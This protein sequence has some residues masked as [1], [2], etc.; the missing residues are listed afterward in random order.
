M[1]PPLRWHSLWMATSCKE[2]YWIRVSKKVCVRNCTNAYP[3][4][5]KTIFRCFIHWNFFF[6]TPRV[7]SDGFK[8][9]WLQLYAAS[10]LFPPAKIFHFSLKRLKLAFS[11]FNFIS[12]KLTLFSLFFVVNNFFL[13]KKTDFL[14]QF[15]SGTTTYQKLP[16]RTKF[17]STLVATPMGFPH[18]RPSHWTSTNI[19]YLLQ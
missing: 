1:T 2:N 3:R 16:K 8:P 7:I 15:L 18:F 6:F 17:N 14:V 12:G 10:G 5:S 19:I 4:K 13:L 11:Y 9:S